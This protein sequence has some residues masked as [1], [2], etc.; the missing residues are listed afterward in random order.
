MAS[1]I[2]GLVKRHSLHLKQI[3]VILRRMNE[4]CTAR[5]VH[6]LNAVQLVSEQLCGFGSS[7]DGLVVTILKLSSGG[8]SRG[9]VP[10]TIH[11]QDQHF[12]FLL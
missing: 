1:R 10:L 5:A 8:Q 9:R 3:R 12:L 7:E 2:H 4:V 6:D 11:I